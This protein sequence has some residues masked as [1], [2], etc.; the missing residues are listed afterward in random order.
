[1]PVLQ[2]VDKSERRSPARSMEAR[3]AAALKAL[4]R[5]LADRAPSNVAVRLWDG[6]V[7]PLS[8]EADGAPAATLVIRTPL[9]LRAIARR[10]SLTS[11]FEVVAG[12]MIEIEGASPLEALRAFD[13]LG[14][15]TFVRSLGARGFVRRLW[16]FLFVKGA[17][18]EGSFA[19]RGAGDDASEVRHHY[20]VSNAFYR[21]FLDERMV[22]SCAYFERPDAT[23]D[24][25][26]RAK[27]DMS[28]RKM[29]LK[30]GAR[31]L[32]IGCG[33]GALAI[34]AARHYGAQVVGITLAEEQ[35]ALAAERVR[36]AG[37]E[38]RVSI[39]LKDWRD[40]DGTEAFDAVVQI[41]MFEHVGRAD[42]EPFLRAVRR[43]LKPDGVYLHHAITRRNVRLTWGQRQ[44]GYAKV[45]DRYIFPGFE[46]DHI[47]RTLADMERCRLE[48]LDVEGWR[49]HYA[50]TCALW[51]E[52]LWE[53]RE[54]A[55]A[56]VGE[57]VTRMWLLYLAMV[58]IGFERSNL[59]IFQTVATRRR[60]GPPPLPATRADLYAD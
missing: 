15:V 40:L 35:H 54:E 38:D 19:Y 13:Y 55:V 53:R 7:V 9:A 58:T 12:G 17:N 49:D 25:A 43:L 22:Y 42:H 37:L 34:H 46:L 36:E 24:E 51:S 52:R 39:E 56:Q 8:A 10:P 20:D 31:V 48:P 33:W 29:R 21:L 32:D 57:A 28:C 6:S 47:G 27:L 1:M 2:D 50:R 41:G 5:D 59:A 45:I 14:T 3:A 44:L 4:L 18:A 60:V 26:Q 30:P 23:M 11:A 16:P